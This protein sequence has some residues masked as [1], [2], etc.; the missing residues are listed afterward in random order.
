M[1]KEELIYNLYLLENLCEEE[2]IAL[3][4]ADKLEYKSAEG[5]WKNFTDFD[6]D[7]IPVLIKTIKPQ[8]NNQEIIYELSYKLLMHRAD[9]TPEKIERII[10]S[11]NKKGL[12]T[13]KYKT[14]E[15]K[16]EN[17]TA[18]IRYKNNNINTFSQ[19]KDPEIILAFIKRNKPKLYKAA[20]IIGESIVSKTLTLK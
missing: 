18:N 16:Y 17:L 20:A 15:N 4:E 12:Y 11:K 2:Q 13:K 1:S 9:I 8:N 14:A 3:I 19:V 6:L 7:Y 5:K 10:F